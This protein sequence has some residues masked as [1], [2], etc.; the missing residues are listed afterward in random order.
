MTA[1]PRTQARQS[2]GSRALSPTVAFGAKRNLR[3]RVASSAGNFASR[4]G[5]A[6][7]TNRAA[8]GG[9]PAQLADASGGS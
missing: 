7:A 9:Y 3:A 6:N 1:A 2:G 4:S 8:F 5:A